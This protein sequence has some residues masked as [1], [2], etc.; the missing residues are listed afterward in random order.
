MQAG[1][2]EAEPW[3]TTKKLKFK[4]SYGFCN[5]V[6]NIYL[7]NERKKRMKEQTAL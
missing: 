4:S 3:E 7:L 1:P 5:S 6:N 2:A